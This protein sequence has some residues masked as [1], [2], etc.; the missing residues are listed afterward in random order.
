MFFLECVG[1]KALNFRRGHKTSLVSQFASHILH[2]DVLLAHALDR[3]ADVVF[4]FAVD[5]ERGGLIRFLD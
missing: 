2:A 3:V 1:C 5:F 4:V